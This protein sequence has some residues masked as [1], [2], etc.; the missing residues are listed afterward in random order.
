MSEKGAYVGGTYQT[1][2]GGYGSAPT[3]H[4]VLEAP[5][6]TTEGGHEPRFQGAGCRD[7]AFAIIFLLH[8]V[9]VGSPRALRSCSS[10]SDVQ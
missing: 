10:A 1:Q 6:Y 5:H 7:L 4:V 3:P 2:P 8:L 9:G